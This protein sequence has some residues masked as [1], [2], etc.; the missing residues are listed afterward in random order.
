LTEI[1][2][3]RPCLASETQ[4]HSC[5]KPA[6][7]I[8]GATIVWHVI[9]RSP[10]PRAR[11]ECAGAT[12]EIQRG[13]IVG[14]AAVE[15]SGHREL[16]RAI[17]GRVPVCLRIAGAPRQHWVCPRMTGIE[18]RWFSRCSLAENFALNGAG[19]SGAG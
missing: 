9:S 10:T 18:M 2:S 12:F 4:V 13:E 8:D 16:L 5:R 7:N 11:R 1:S 15:G 19:D 14:V 17:A 3:S 6:R